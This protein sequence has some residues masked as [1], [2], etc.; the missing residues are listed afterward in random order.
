VEKYQSKISHAFEFVGNSEKWTEFWLKSQNLFGKVIQAS[1]EDL[2]KALEIRSDRVRTLN[3]FDTHGTIIR[4]GIIELQDS[5]YYVRAAVRQ[6]FSG[7]LESLKNNP[8]L[9]SRMGHFLRLRKGLSTSHRYFVKQYFSSIPEFQTLLNLA[10]AEIA[11]LRKA[12]TRIIRRT[13]KWFCRRF[14]R[15]LRGNL[16]ISSFLISSHHFRCENEKLWPLLMAFNNP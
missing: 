11:A 8:E 15:L 12:L 16:I 4:T 6:S 13:T 7:L 2:D 5:R 1:I 9:A 10:K 3:C 14:L